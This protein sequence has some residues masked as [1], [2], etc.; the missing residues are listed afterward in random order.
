MT[1]ATR[2]DMIDRF[3]EGD[4]ARLTDRADPPLEAIDDTVLNAALADAKAQIDAYV[5]ARY[6]LPLPTVPTV[7]KGYECDLAWF[8][9]QRQHPTDE[10]TA[11]HKAAMSFLR[12]VSTG[13]VSLGP[14]AT[15]TLQAETGGVFITADAPVFSPSTLSDY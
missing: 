5:A 12:D 4:L 6:A 8:I 2:Q 9:L 10:A 1:Y 11:R 13:R 14:D 3:G 15:N 7:L